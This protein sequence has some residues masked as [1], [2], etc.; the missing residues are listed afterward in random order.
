VGIVFDVSA[1]ITMNA[2]V[3]DE[4][5]RALLE[6]VRRGDG[7]NEYFVIGFNK[8][9]HLLADWTRDPAVVAAGLNA[10]TPLQ[11]KGMGGRVFY[12]GLYEALGKVGK[13]A[14]P[15][16]VLLV[17]SDGDDNGSRRR[18]PEVRRL[19]ATGGALVYALGI[20]RHE[21]AG[22]IGN[23]EGWRNLS[24]LCR[25]SGGREFYLETFRTPWQAK[26]A[27]ADPA[28]DVKGALETIALELSNQYRIR[29]KPSSPSNKPEWRRVE[30][31]VRAPGVPDKS[32]PV[33]AREGYLSGGK[34]H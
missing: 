7:S 25:A 29:F 31:K 19:A 3:L 21:I 14:N 15:K 6:F 2:E 23:E 20:Y 34:P 28:A 27:R 22:S 17:V 11:N 1:S 30:V 13:G 8:A 16:R 24:A 9:S 26:V 10:L 12:V 32:F 18:F 33:R 5:R 4:A